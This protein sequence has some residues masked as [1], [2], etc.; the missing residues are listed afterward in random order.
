MSVSPRGDCLVAQL[1]FFCIFFLW[2]PTWS[3]IINEALRL[4]GF[5]GPDVDV[6]FSSHKG[7]SPTERH[8]RYHHHHCNLH[9]NIQL[10]NIDDHTRHSQY[11]SLHMFG[12]LDLVID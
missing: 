1:A 7:P 2:P 8:S 10:K 5:D 4:K 6:Y 11:Y 9:G 3:E 12:Y